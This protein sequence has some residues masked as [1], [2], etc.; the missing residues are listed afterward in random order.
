MSDNFLVFLCSLLIHVLDPPLKSFILSHK[1]PYSLLDD[2]RRF[3]ASHKFFSLK[4]VLIFIQFFQT[5]KFLSKLLSLSAS[6]FENCTPHKHQ[7]NNTCFLINL[8]LLFTFNLSLFF[9]FLLIIQRLLFYKLI[10]LNY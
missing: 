10:F 4:F 9:V 2:M 6:F 8:F 3:L 5:H 1:S 7:S